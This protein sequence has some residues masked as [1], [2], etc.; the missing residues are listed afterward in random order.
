MSSS[1]VVP[2]QMLLQQQNEDLIKNFLNEQKIKVVKKLGQGC[3]AE[4]F[5][6]IQIDKNRKVAIKSDLGLSQ[7]IERPDLQQILSK[8]SKTIGGN[9]KYMSPEIFFQTKPY[10]IKIDIFSI[11]QILLEF[12]LKRELTSKEWYQLKTDELFSTIPEL[13]N[14]QNINFIQQILAK[15]VCHE[16]NQRLDL[17]TLLQ[18]LNQYQPNEESLKTLEYSTKKLN[19]EMNINKEINIKNNINNQINQN[20][21]NYL[22]VSDNKLIDKKNIKTVILDKNNYYGNINYGDFQ[23]TLFSYITTQDVVLI[24]EKGGYI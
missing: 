18:K 10:T 3:F 23:Q 22:L 19:Q 12:V 2:Q 14:N 5:E 9:I 20:A 4:V 16:S 11:G 17:M 1:N 8:A 7:I 13:Q 24:N 21:L 6:A 15:M